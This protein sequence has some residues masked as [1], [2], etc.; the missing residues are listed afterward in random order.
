MKFRTLI[1]SLSLTTATLTTATAHA[2][3]G[4]AVPLY[5]ES[6]LITL[7]ETNS[8]LERVK[9]DECQ[10]VQD[11]EARATRVGSPAY[12]FLYGDMLAWGVCVEQDADLGVYYMKLA[13]QQGLP[14]ALEQIGRY[15]ANGTLV[16]QD[17]H[18]AIPYLREA[19]SLGDTRA[20]IQLAELLVDDVGSPLDYEDA[21]RWL[22]QTITAD[23]RTR[24]R[25]AQLRSALE[26]RMPQNI[27][28]RAKRRTSYW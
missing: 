2:D 13:A 3:V 16:Q 5:E 27:I 26:A 23:S 15:Y 17:Q 8:H 28:A 20:R 19:A 22:Y 14:A 18:R 11:I 9:Q 12:E 7:F 21:Y 6:E 25:I 1:F 4:A 10:L 24:N